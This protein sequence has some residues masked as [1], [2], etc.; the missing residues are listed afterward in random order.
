MANFPRGLLLFALVLTMVLAQ[1]HTSLGQNLIKNPSFE[2]DS[3]ICE[4]E[5][6]GYYVYPQWCVP[7]NFNVFSLHT[8]RN[9]SQGGYNSIPK[10]NFGYQWPKHG[11]AYIAMDFFTYYYRQFDNPSTRNMYRNFLQGSLKK[12][13]KPGRKYQLTFFVS[14]RGNDV[15]GRENGDLSS[16]GGVSNLD[17][18]LTDQNFCGDFNLHLKLVD[19]YGRSKKP[20]APQIRNSRDRILADTGRWMQVKGTF[21][22]DG[23]ESRFLVGVFADSGD[24][25]YEQ[26]YP[27]RTENLFT[28]SY[29]LDDFSLTP[30]P[31]LDIPSDTLVLCNQEP[32]PLHPF[33]DDSLHQWHNGQQTD[34]LQARQTGLHWAR[35]SN[36]DTTVTDSVMIYRLQDLDLGPD[37]VICEGEAITLSPN[38]PRNLTYTWDNGDTTYSRTITQPG[39]YGVTATGDSCKVRDTI[40]V[41]DTSLTINLGPD[42]TLCAGDAYP[43]SVPE[44][45]S[46]EWSNGENSATIRVNS[47][48]SYAVQVSN[49]FCAAADTIQVGYQQA[50]KATVPPDTSFCKGDTFRLNY[51]PEYALFR[52]DSPAANPLS[53][54]RPGTYAIRISNACGAITGTLNLKERPCPCRVWFP[55]AFTPGNDNLNEVFRPRYDCR[56][57]NFQLTI[58]NRWGQLVYQTH[59]IENGW[60]PDESMPAGVYHWQ[61]VYTGLENGLLRKRAESGRI[62]L[63]R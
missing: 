35:L 21:R 43:L 33:P 49:G 47:P 61:A 44:S 15:S 10:N 39:T 31:S 54:T 24:I 37:T 48:G 53:F 9:E 3:S 2:Q 4:M 27:E 25:R 57:Q 55:E 45:L 58:Y 28:V 52:N 23:G 38:L 8:C 60:K 30:L 34:T 50:P 32:R 1:T 26:V 12:T 36:F 16:P 41:R 46:A 63:I 17:V 40:V 11:E 51:Q 5:W 62:R 13:L 6:P 7:R 14:V 19:E 56:L 18:W 20:N 22:A 29:Y 59:D 42:T